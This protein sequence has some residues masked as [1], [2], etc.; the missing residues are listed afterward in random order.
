[1][2]EANQAAKSRKQKVEDEAF[3]AAKKRIKLELEKDSATV[4][5]VC[6]L[7]TSLGKLMDAERKGTADD[8]EYGGQL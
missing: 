5:D 1:M 8:G 7:V 6:S 4:A 2:T 3:I